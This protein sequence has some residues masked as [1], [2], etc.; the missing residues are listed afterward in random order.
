[1]SFGNFLLFQSETKQQ[2][3]STSNILDNDVKLQIF[4]EETTDLGLAQGQI[5]K[6]ISSMRNLGRTIYFVN[7]AKQASNMIFIHDDLQNKTQHYMTIK[8][9]RLLTNV[10]YIDNNNYLLGIGQL[11][12]HVKLDAKIYEPIYKSDDLCGK[13]SVMLVHN[14][15]GKMMICGGMHQLSVFMADEKG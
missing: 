8:D 9:H 3:K 12:Y 7:T 14:K 11:V 1:M 15:L 2:Q 5:I 13:V 4:E 10:E 6:A